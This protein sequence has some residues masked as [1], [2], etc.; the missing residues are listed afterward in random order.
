MP[1]PQYTN[2]LIYSSRTVLHLINFQKKSNF[3]PAHKKG[4]KQLIKKLPTGVFITN[5][6][7]ING[8]N[9][10]QLNFRFY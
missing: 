10:A 7:K 9:Y 4:D 1:P 2:H 3:V 6:R 5:L 8:K